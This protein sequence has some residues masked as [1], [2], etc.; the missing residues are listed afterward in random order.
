MVLI[1]QHENEF[2]NSKHAS[3][4]TRSRCDWASHKDVATGASRAFILHAQIN[5]PINGAVKGRRLVYN[6]CHSL[7]FTRYLEGI[8][9]ASKSVARPGALALL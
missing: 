1:D 7:D 3:F 8:E 9:L 4:E 6:L 2:C 5:I